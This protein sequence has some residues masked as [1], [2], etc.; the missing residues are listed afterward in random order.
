[1]H[2][3]LDNVIAFF[4]QKPTLIISEKN[5]AC[6]HGS[7]INYITQSGKMKYEVCRNN[8]S[9]HNLNIDQKLIALGIEVN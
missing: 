2:G 7:A 9:S 4:N 1:M 3:N 6:K 8:I 5:G